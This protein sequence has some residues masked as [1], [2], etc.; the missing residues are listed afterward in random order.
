MKKA[1]TLFIT[2]SMSSAFAHTITVNGEKAKVLT[3]LILSSPISSY[4]DGHAGGYDV[5]VYDVSCH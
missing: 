1:I 5:S 4:A 3:D 2:L